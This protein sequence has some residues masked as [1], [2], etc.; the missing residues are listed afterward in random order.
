VVTSI[1]A[2]TRLLVIGTVPCD[3][4]TVCPHACLVIL[5]IDTVPLYFLSLGF[6]ISDPSP[7]CTV[8]LLKYC[9]DIHDDPSPSCTVCLLKYCLDIHD[10]PSPSWTVCLLKYCLDIHDD[11]S[12]SCTVCLLKYCLDIHDEPSPSW[13]I[14]ILKYCL[15]IHDDPS[16]SWTICILKYCLDKWLACVFTVHMSNKHAS[17]LLTV[18][19]PSWHLPKC[20]LTGVTADMSEV[21]SVER[22][23]LTFLTIVVRAAGL[24]L[25]PVQRCWVLD[26][27]L[28]LGMM[29]VWPSH[30][31][32][33]TFTSPLVNTSKYRALANQIG[34]SQP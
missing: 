4:I 33:L 25:I 20:P 3:L 6:R 8:C 10:D 24:H 19:H 22:T 13:T 1:T 32:S 11:P 23:A 17:G 26:T 12:P 30:R 16:P 7:S 31:P 29:M 18:I 21:L 27:Q 2:S 9:L 28:G 5:V 14:C 34:H 15:D